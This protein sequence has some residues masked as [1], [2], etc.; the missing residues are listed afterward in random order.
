[1][2]SISYP[3]TQYADYP[4]TTSPLSVPALRDRHPDPLVAGVARRNPHLQVI[5]GHHR[6]SRPRAS[7]PRCTVPDLR[8]RETARPTAAEISRMRRA[9]SRT[10]VPGHLARH[11]EAAVPGRSEYGKTWRCVSGERLEIAGQLLEVLVGLAG[12]PDDDVG[13]DRRV[14]ECARECR[15]R[16]RRTARRC[17]AAASRCSIRSLACCSGRWKCGAKQS[18]LGDQRHDLRACSPSARAS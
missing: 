15:R 6:A 9:R 16:A 1:M 18:C 8:R 4:I 11:G 12:E 5:V 7:G 14:R 2:R 3:A 13:A 10:T 17:T